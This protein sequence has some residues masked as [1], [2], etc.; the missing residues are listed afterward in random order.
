M[1]T[2]DCLPFSTVHLT[3]DMLSPTVKDREAGMSTQL[4]IS[5]A[6]AARDVGARRP[7]MRKGKRAFPREFSLAPSRFLG[8]AGDSGRNQPQT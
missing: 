4:V 2:A 8:L 3:H 7:C 1:G 5:Y 6:D